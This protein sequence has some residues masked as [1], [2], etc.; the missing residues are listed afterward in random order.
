M[1][2]E[3]RRKEEGERKM[4]WIATNRRKVEKFEDLDTN[5]V[6]ELLD[7]TNKPEKR[8]SNNHNYSQGPHTDPFSVPLF[9]KYYDSY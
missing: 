9:P 4:G 8:S 5:K 2:T 3:N 7:H 1:E 6:E